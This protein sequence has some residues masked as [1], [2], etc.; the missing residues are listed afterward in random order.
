MVPLPGRTTFYRLVDAAVGRAAHVR[1]G[2]HA[3]ADWRTGRQ[4]AFTP[5]LAA[6][7]GEQVQIDSTPLDV[8]VVLDDGVPAGRS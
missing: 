3:P 2:G 5:T 8:L 4:G 6:R 7:P 1:L